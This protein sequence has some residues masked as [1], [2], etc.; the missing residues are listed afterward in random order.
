MIKAATNDLERR[1]DS[2]PFRVA[3]HGDF[4]PWNILETRD[5]LRVI[6]WENVATDCPA[7]YDYYHFKLLPIA[8]KGTIRRS[9]IDDCLKPSLDPTI[10]QWR[11]GPHHATTQ[12]LAYVLD[13][14]TLRISRD[15]G[16]WGPSPIARQ[17]S[18]LLSH[19]NDWLA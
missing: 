13:V 15:E 12:L 16:P 4:A 11:Q 3:A 2:H 1:W 8:L 10:D 19:R 5:G 17:Y 9:H 18:L 6:D 7:L 14:L